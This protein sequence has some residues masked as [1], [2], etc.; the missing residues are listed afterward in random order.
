[1]ININDIKIPTIVVTTVLI[2]IVIFHS[3]FSRFV[4]ENEWIRPT[5]IPETL[6]NVYVWPPGVNWLGT[7]ISENFEV[8]EFKKKIQEDYKKYLKE[9]KETIEKNKQLLN[10]RKE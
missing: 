5:P 9:R 2:L 4:G 8:D 1:M 10:N 6:E 3:W 7:P